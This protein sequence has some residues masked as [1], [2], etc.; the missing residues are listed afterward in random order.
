MKYVW[1]ELAFLEREEQRSLERLKVLRGL[2]KQFKQ[3]SNGIQ[4]KEKQSKESSKT[5]IQKGQ[6]TQEKRF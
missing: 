5:I 3:E 2:I 6:S 1:N 4:E